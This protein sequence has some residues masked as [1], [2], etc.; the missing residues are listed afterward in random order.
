[1]VQFTGLC[2]KNGNEI[3]EGDIV[4]HDAWDY[5]FEI[6]FNKEKARFVCKMKTGLTQYIDCGGLKVVG[7]VYE[8]HDVLST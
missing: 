7:N 8:N 3:F 1:V 2:D 6:V 5:P 4:E